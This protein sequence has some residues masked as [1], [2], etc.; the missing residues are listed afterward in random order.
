MDS[1]THSVRVEFFY[2]F[3]LVGHAAEF[4]LFLLVMA[5][6]F[7]ATF[8]AVSGSTVLGRLGALR[9]GSVSVV[10]FKLVVLDIHGNLMVVCE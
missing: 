4:V 8:L 7:L 1:I 6:V 3:F 2:R 10:L 9:L 5:T